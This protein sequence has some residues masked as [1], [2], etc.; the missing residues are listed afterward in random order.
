MECNHKPIAIYLK[1]S[2][3]RNVLYQ[4]KCKCL[5]ESKI[6]V[7][8]L[9]KIIHTVFIVFWINSKKFKHQFIW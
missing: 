2:I 5:S 4:C 9:L 7:I 3:I 1:D 6:L 8:K